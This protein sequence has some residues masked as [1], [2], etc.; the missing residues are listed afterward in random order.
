[1]CLQRLLGRWQSDPRRHRLQRI[2]STFPAGWPGAGLL[3]LRTTLGLTLVT[4]SAGYFVNWHDL[5]SLTR[6]V[7][8]L[9]GVSGVSLSVGYVTPFAGVVGGVVTVNSA[10]S[11]PSLFDTRLA[12][13]LAISIAVAI[14]C[15]GPGAFSIDARLF[16]RRE[17][18]IPDA[19]HPPKA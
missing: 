1:M 8:L 12:T 11:Y 9:A 16:G 13:V 6:L 19:S 17:I 2:F 10:M 7:A 18:V 4:Q 14:L 15:L 3:L 5:G